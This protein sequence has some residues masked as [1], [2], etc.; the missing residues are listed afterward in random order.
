MFTHRSLLE[1]LF[2]NAIRS[3]S[4]GKQGSYSST[5]LS[6]NLDLHEIVLSL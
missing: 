2:T 6:D 3:F 1:D 5:I 4:I